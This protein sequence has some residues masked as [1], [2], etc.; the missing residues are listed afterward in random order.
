M[1]IAHQAADVNS[2]APSGSQR[3]PDGGPNRPSRRGYGN[4]SG[5]GR[6]STYHRSGLVTRLKLG[7]PLIAGVIIALVLAWPHV[8]PNKH[9]FPLGGSKIA[10]QEAEQLRMTNARFVGTDQK[11]QPYVVTAT[12]AFEASPTAATVDLTA[13]KADLTQKTGAWTWGSSLTGIYHRDLKTLDLIDD[14]TIFQDT[15]AE[16]HTSKATID[17]STHNASGDQPVH[18]QSPSGTIEGQG[19]TITNHGQVITFT[20][21]SKALLR[22]RPGGA[23]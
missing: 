4:A 18:G 8:V 12:S 2:G 19:F 5:R 23:S 9:G 21:K 22:Q 6:G 16:F 11:D 1:T 13:P 17:L 15:G 10:P 7:L 3:G 14:V 20:G